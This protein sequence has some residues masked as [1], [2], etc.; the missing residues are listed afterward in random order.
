MS[1]GSQLP[2][3]ESRQ[4]GRPSTVMDKYSC[5]SQ[6]MRTSHIVNMLPLGSAAK[7]NSPPHHFSLLNRPD[8]VGNPFASVF[9]DMISQSCQ[10][11]QIEAMVYLHQKH[12]VVCHLV[13]FWIAPRQI[14]ESRTAKRHVKLN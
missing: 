13:L 3:R 12:D 14:E 9:T 7:R 8:L 10:F 4:P 2:S 5:R 11:V 1:L 6:R